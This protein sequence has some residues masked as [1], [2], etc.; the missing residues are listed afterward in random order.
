MMIG[1]ATH[2]SSTETSSSGTSSAKEVTKKSLFF[3][4]VPLAKHTSPPA[5]IRVSHIKSYGSPGLPSF[6]SNRKD[7]NKSFY[8]SHPHARWENCLS[9]QNAV[10]HEAKI[11]P[12]LNVQPN[13]VAASPLKP[14]NMNSNIQ[15]NVRV[16]KPML[17][18]ASNSSQPF[19]IP[20]V[21]PTAPLPIKKATPIKNKHVSLAQQSLFNYK[22]APKFIEAY[23]LRDELGSGGFGF[24][25]TVRGILFSNCAHT[26]L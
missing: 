9:D 25:V 7:T 8:P 21:A 15:A 16:M 3:Q 17:F 10:Q 20:S 1:Q 26:T 18:R 24:V 12:K 14:R 13:S 5:T 19:S 11:L 23:T 4:P 6:P 2:K 22:L